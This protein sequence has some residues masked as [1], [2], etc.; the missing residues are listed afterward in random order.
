MQPENAA[1]DGFIHEFLAA[2]SA[3]ADILENLPQ[4]DESRFQAALGDLQ[5]QLESLRPDADAGETRQV[6]WQQ[7]TMIAGQLRPGYQALHPVSDS[8][9]VAQAA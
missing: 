4:W 1:A 5:A 7:L 8:E 6:L 3:A 9:A 2:G